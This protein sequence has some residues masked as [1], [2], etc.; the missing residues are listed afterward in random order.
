MVD[1]G[2]VLSRLPSRDDVVGSVEQ[3]PVAREAASPF[4]AGESAATA[5][6]V[7]AEV[8]AAG[9]SASV[10]HLPPPDAL[11]TVLVG[12]MQV[13]DALGTADLS[14]GTD[15]ALNP[16]ALGLGR[17]PIDT[18]AAKVA[19]LCRAATDAGMTVTLTSVPHAL[20]ADVLALWVGLAGDLPDLGVTLTANLHRTEGDCLDL[21]GAGARVRLLRQEVAEQPGVAFTDAHEIDKAYVR[22]TRLLFDNGARPILATEDDRLIEIAVALGE[23]AD[24]SPGEYVIQFRRGLRDARAAELVASG[25]TVA[26]LIPFGPGWGAYVTQWITATPSVL[27]RALGAV[28]GRSGS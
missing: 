20:V 15:L 9:M 18:V 13:I 6:V 7:V 21:A 8:V 17:V 1:F 12:S 24:R 22:C 16:V 23:R 11:E 27:G 25:A 19:G 2:S 5:T 4:I 10:L 3:M 28:L 14:V 26:V